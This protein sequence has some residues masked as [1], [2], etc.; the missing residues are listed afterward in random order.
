[1]KRRV[2]FLTVLVLMAH[3]L[4][5]TDQ[6]KTVTLDFDRIN[7]KY[8]TE[9]FLQ[10]RSFLESLDLEELFEFT[11][12]LSLDPEEFSGSGMLLIEPLI[13]KWNEKPYEDELLYIIGCKEFN[14][15]FRYYF[16]CI[17]EQRIKQGDKKYNDLQEILL[18]I[19]SDTDEQDIYRRSAVSSLSWKTPLVQQRIIQLVEQTDSSELL[20]SLV[21]A[22][23]SSGSQEFDRYISD[24]I[25]SP[26]DYQDNMLRLAIRY[27]ELTPEWDYLR[28]FSEI[29]QNTDSMTVYLEILERMGKMN[30][31][32][33]VMSF[34]D[35]LGRFGYGPTS[36]EGH[37]HAD[38]SLKLWPSQ[39][40]VRWM[41]SAKQDHS[42]EIII[43]G[44]KAIRIGDMHF[45]PEMVH[46]VLK[47]RKDDEV[48]REGQLSV[49]YLKDKSGWHSESMLQF[50]REYSEYEGEK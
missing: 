6:K 27:I 43:Y 9:K 1:M 19:A 5:C 45:N 29:A 48:Q 26:Y 11:Y 10:D 7:S 21:F 14:R 8:Y 40:A 4:S 16:L 42:D 36:F 47:L 22:L 30:T 24:V 23:R 2:V 50:H 34:I 17:A 37:K 35:N 28:T 49:N 32:Q 31:M 44:L 20:P 39:A 3:L 46:E 18:N 41:L 25:H 38:I 13:E 33:A 15:H 12:E